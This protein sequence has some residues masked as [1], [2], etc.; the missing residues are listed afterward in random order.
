MKVKGSST[1][2]VVLKL[3]FFDPPPPHVA[4]FQIA[5]MVF[6]RTFLTPPPPLV[7]YVV[8]GWPLTLWNF[9]LTSWWVENCCGSRFSFKDSIQTF[10]AFTGFLSQI[11]QTLIALSIPL[12]QEEEFENFCNHFEYR[13]ETEGLFIHYE[14]Y[15]RAVDI[16]LYETRTTLTTTGGW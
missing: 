2:H 16:R 7:V 14:K 8:C 3:G 11:C 1:N 12:I 15:L 13:Y 5:D 10:R 4:T 6:S 9:S